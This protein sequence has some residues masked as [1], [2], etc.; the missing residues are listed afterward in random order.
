MV[1]S[2]NTIARELKA[3]LRERVSG[4]HVELSLGII[5]VKETPA[6]RQ[7][8]AF[9]ERFG[10]DISIDVELIHL[11]ALEQT[12]EKLLQLLLHSTRAHQGLILQLPIPPRFSLE[13]VFSLYPMS[14]DVDVLGNTAY[15]QFKEGRL[16]FLPPVVGAIR[17]VLHR[18]SIRLLGKNVVV[19]GEGRLVGA[20]ASVWAQQERANVTI[21]NKETENITAYTKEADVIITGTG[22]PGLIKPD[23]IKEGVIL[24]DAGSGEMAGVLMGD[25]D[26]LCAEKASIFTPT[27][28]GLGPITVAKVFE[29]FLD[30]YELK[31]KQKPF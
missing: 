9:K 8:I 12:D 27:P 30:L 15:Q 10:K 23:M 25:V 11:P 7:F 26:P 19:V 3:K 22:N 4:I 17:E 13:N 29:N 14:H 28:G 2:G 24:L 21:V 16:P 18:N 6:I 1:I 20:P 5:V 31:N